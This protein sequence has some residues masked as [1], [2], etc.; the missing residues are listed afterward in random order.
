MELIQVKQLHS[1]VETAG[2]A[3]MIA[4]LVSVC[5]P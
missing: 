4:L 1:T 3:V 2:E 5:G